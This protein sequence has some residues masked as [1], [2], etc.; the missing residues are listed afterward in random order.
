[1]YHIWLDEVQ[2]WKFPGGEIGVKLSSFR[3]CHTQIFARLRSSDEVM[4][5]V[6]TV[7]ALRRCGVEDLSLYI[8]Y[9][10][11]GR[12][13]RQCNDM[14][15]FSL[16]VFANL[17]N[18][19]NFKWVYVYDEH[20]PVT[21]ALLDRATNI[22]NTA[23]ALESIKRI[24]DPNLVLISPDAGAYKKVAKLQE[25][26][27][28]EVVYATKT[29]DLSTGKLTNV[30]FPFQL[31]GKSCLVIDDICDGGATFL[32]LGAKL[33]EAGAGKLYLAVSHGIFS[34][35][36]NDLCKYYNKIFTTNS[37]YSEQEYKSKFFWSIPMNYDYKPEYFDVFDI[38]SGAYTR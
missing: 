8:P 4:K 12:Q 37:F 24:G 22:E 2:Y 20:S 17:I 14:E 30:S 36:L 6:M 10:P 9:T 35:G 38:F 11:Y 5:L 1:M 15:S 33:K 26:V 16:K 28:N 7:D 29:R 32:G 3:R 21:T 23:F 31:E 13:D 25:Y 34:K 19:L 18:S 27:S